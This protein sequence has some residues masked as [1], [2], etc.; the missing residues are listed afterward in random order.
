MTVYGTVRSTRRISH[1]VICWLR[2]SV[3][4]SQ[5]MQG[6]S[7]VRCSYLHSVTVRVRVL[8]SQWYSQTCCVQVRTWLSRWHTLTV[9][10][11]TWGLQTWTWYVQG[12]WTVSSLLT[13]T[14]TGSFTQFGTQQRRDRWHGSQAPQ[15]GTG[16]SSQCP[17][18]TQRVHVSLTG[19]QCVSQRVPWR[20]S[21]EGTITVH[22]SAWSVQT[23]TQTVYWV[24]TVLI[25]G[26]WT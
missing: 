20:V 17:L 8:V 25:V 15:A 12:T 16:R 22:C 19:T 1:V 23:G 21:H 24:A 18:S 11:W 3:F 14:S 10:L 6:T 5:T 26:T 4:A 2:V 7:R 9:R 13:V